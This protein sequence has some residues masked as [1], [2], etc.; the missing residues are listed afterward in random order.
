MWVPLVLKV[1]GFIV[2]ALLAIVL[3]DRNRRGVA[4]RRR[5]PWPADQRRI[6][7]HRWPTAGWHRGT[8]GPSEAEARRIEGG[9][10]HD[11]DL[12][13]VPVDELGFAE[14]DDEDDEDDE[15]GVVTV[16]A[17]AAGPAQPLP[18]APVDAGDVARTAVAVGGAVG[19]VAKKGLAR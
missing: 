4:G 19:A 3:F 5:Q 14:P 6:R 13:E 7:R 17:V 11:A 12:D 8:S 18:P 15:D 2:L 1:A 10:A 9:W 16:I